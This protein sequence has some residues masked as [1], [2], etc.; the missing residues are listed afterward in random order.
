MQITKDIYPNNYTT[1]SYTTLYS[2]F[3]NISYSTTSIL[4]PDLQQV[5]SNGDTCSS[6]TPYLK[7]TT[8]AVTPIIY[9]SSGTYGYYLA[10]NSDKKNYSVSL[11]NTNGTALTESWISLEKSYIATNN[12]FYLYIYAYNYTYKYDL[13]TRNFT[14]RIYVETPDPIYYS[15]TDTNFSVISDPVLLTNISDQSFRI[16]E[17][18]SFLLDYRIRYT[19]TSYYLSIVYSN[20]SSFSYYSFNATSKMMVVCITDPS[21]VIDTYDMKLRFYYYSG[22]IREYPFKMSLIG[23]SPPIFDYNGTTVININAG[24]NYTFDFPYA[25]DADN[26]TIYYFMSG[27]SYFSYTKYSANNT[28]LFYNADNYDYGD[29]TFTLYA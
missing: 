19:I 13:D 21:F 20:G 4:S 2:S 5:D 18:G 9:T 14:I 12:T 17:I 16:G 15:Y 7:N 6:P 22:D 1:T 28:Y 8:I 3:S 27:T 26:E 11:Q 29:Y 25:T 23:N 24:Y 10:I